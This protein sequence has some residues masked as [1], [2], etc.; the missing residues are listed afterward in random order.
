MASPSTGPVSRGTLTPLL[1]R[2]LRKV[3]YET[4]KEQPLEYPMVAN[5]DTMDWNPVRDQ[6]VIGIGNMPVK[7]E[8]SQFPLDAHAIGGT[9]DYTAQPRGMAIE[10]TWEGYRDELYGV[11]QEMVGEMGRATRQA[12]EVDFWSL[13]NNAFDTA[14]A[15]FTSGESLCGAHT[16]NDLVVRRNRPAVDIGMSQTYIQGSILR[17][18]TM[19]TERN[20]P[21]LLRPTM[22]IVTPTGKVAAREVLGSSG[23]PY[24]ADN[25]MNALIEE[26]LSWMVAHYLT[27][28]TTQFLIAAKG[29]HDLNFLWRDEPIFDSF[30]DPWT[31]NAV[32][33]AYQRYAFGYGSWR[34]VDGSFG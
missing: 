16:G 12:Q 11:C 29:V 13:L 30:D 1:A 9:K 22:A 14:F 26:D 25:E 28:Q 17:F 7:P 19:T 32:F 6:Q 20:N 21:R 8:G 15:G 33:T 34:G 10:F 5:V 31:K 3:Y 4:G 23:K 18:E 2:D 27:N 24:T